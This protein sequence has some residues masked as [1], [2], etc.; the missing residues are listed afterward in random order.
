MGIMS[1]IDSFSD[2]IGGIWWL[3]VY[4]F[5]KLPFINASQK[6]SGVVVC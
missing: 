4:F 1:L 6:W 2:V 3:K 5:L